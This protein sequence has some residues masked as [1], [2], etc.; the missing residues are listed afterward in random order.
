M[1]DSSRRRCGLL[2]SLLLPG[3][4]ARPLLAKPSADAVEML[5]GP[6][7]SPREDFFGEAYPS[8]DR[9]L[10]QLNAHMLRRHSFG[11]LIAHRNQEGA[12]VSPFND[13]LGFDGGG[14]KIILGLR[15]GITDFLDIG[16]LRQNG[17]VEN[18]DT[19]ELDSRL[20]LFDQASGKP[21]DL[22]VRLG[23]DWFNGPNYNAAGFFTQL[24]VAR[25]VAQRARVGGGVLFASSSSGPTK[26]DNDA[27]QSAAVM[28][29]GDVRLLGSLDLAAEFTYTVAGFHERFPVITVGPK[30]VSNRH[31]FSWVLSNSQ[32]MTADSLVTNTYRGKFKQWVL[33]FHITREIDI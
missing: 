17:T 24:L 29:Q 30:I 19:W 32:Y 12:F 25:V 3:L 21:F 22:T 27:K 6:S 8:L 16:A 28:L 26:S 18:F 7:L 11:S 1:P 4:L 5:D 15:Y 2:L 9:T 31:T 10:D 20:R 23:V 14:L 33:G 13:L